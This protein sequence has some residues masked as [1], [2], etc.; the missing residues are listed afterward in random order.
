M[1]TEGPSKRSVPSRASWGPTC[2]SSVFVCCIVEM[3][4]VSQCRCIPLRMIGILL[5]QVMFKPFAHIRPVLHISSRPNLPH[6]LCIALQHHLPG[7]PKEIFIVIA[8]TRSVW[9]TRGSLRTPRIL[10]GY[11][12]RFKDADSLSPRSQASEYF[13]R[14]SEIPGGYGIRSKDAASCHEA[15]CN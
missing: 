9:H 15:R 12:R 13:R 1:A 14:E 5:A 3:R 7:Y 11:G 2:T 10:M 6:G 8:T 4:D